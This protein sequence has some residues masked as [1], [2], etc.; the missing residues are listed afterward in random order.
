MI[1][2]M[3]SNVKQTLEDIRNKKQL[4]LVIEESCFNPK[5][6]EITFNVMTDPFFEDDMVN[7]VYELCKQFSLLYTKSSVKIKTD[8]TIHDGENVSWLQS[9]IKICMEEVY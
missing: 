5:T 6:Y 2:K 1:E 4:E 9:Q 8:K 7:N 3:I